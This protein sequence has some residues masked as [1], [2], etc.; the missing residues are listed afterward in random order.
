M[1]NKD[2][3][4]P[5]QKRKSWPHDVDTPGHCLKCDEQLPSLGWK[6][7]YCSTKC[8]REDTPAASWNVERGKI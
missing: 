8:E 7:A 2:V 5:K 3:E 4:D 6:S 1:S